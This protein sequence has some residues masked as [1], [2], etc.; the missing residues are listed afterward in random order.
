MH[1]LQ[2]SDDKLAEEHAAAFLLMAALSL[3]AGCLLYLLI[4]RIAVP[5]QVAR[6]A[7]P[8]VLILVSAFALYCH[9]RRRIRVGLLALGIGVWLEIT[10]MAT[11]TG[12]M[13]APAIYLYPLIILM[14]GWP[15]GMSA[16]PA[17]QPV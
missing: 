14:A 17:L 9:R 5:D 13:K 16:L 6:M 7:G 8:A 4:L 10:L 3:A 2:P 15:T 1:S 12:G 11:I